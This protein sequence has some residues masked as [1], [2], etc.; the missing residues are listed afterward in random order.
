MYYVPISLATWAPYPA[1]Q[2]EN[3]GDLE[4]PDSVDAIDRS[5]RGDWLTSPPVP[6]AEGTSSSE[7]RCSESQLTSK[8][9][10]HFIGDLEGPDSVDARLADRCP[11]INK[12]PKNQFPSIAGLQNPLCGQNLSFE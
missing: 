10:K 12:I 5:T 7:R 6:G 1:N 3:K 8:K 11:Y 4:G 9:T 2:Q